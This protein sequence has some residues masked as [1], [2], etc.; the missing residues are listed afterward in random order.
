MIVNLI[1]ND[2]FSQLGSDTSTHSVELTAIV[3]T[4]MARKRKQRVKKRK[5]QKGGARFRRKPPLVD[6]IAEGVAMGLSG[7]SPNFIKLG[8]F[9][10]KQALKG[11]KDNVR[12]YQ[13]GK[14]LSTVL[15]TA[16]KIGYKLGKD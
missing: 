5:S 10:G 3:S 6:K 13:K 9:L 11:I 16:A 14:G 4:T 1:K 2:F 7:P 12:H 15:S 8:A